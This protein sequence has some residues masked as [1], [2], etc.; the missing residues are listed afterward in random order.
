[1]GMP[2]SET[3]LKELCHVLG[4]LLEES[5]VPKLAD[6]IYCWGNTI[7]ELQRNYS[8]LLQCLVT[9]VSVFPPQKRPSAHQA[10]LVGC[11]T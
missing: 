6:D 2:G 9:A 5:I 7:T 8:R 11:G 4:C 3:A 10:Y 1:M